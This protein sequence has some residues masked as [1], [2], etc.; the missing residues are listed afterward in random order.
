M[1]D[2]DD[3]RDFL[4]VSEYILEPAEVYT[5]ENESCETN[6]FLFFYRWRCVS[7]QSQLN[8]ADARSSCTAL[9]WVICFLFTPNIGRF[10]IFCTER[11]NTNWRLHHWTTEAVWEECCD[12]RRPKTE[13]CFCH[14]WRLSARKAIIRRIDEMSL[15][16]SAEVRLKSSVCPLIALL[17]NPVTHSIAGFYWNRPVISL[18]L[19]LET[20]LEFIIGKR[21]K[22]RGIVCTLSS[23]RVYPE[24]FYFCTP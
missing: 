10:E 4:P 12:F 24:V 22:A 19:L 13:S 20:W 9:D 21:L 17:C 5:R 15:F 18:Q 23:G 14:I 16:C 1:W 2:S 8:W 3:L 6:M 7:W 11:W